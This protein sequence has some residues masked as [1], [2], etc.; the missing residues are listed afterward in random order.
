MGIV[1]V[2][3]LYFFLPS[4]VAN[5]VPLILHRYGLFKF[6]DIRVDFG[7]KINGED[8][9]GATKSY[10]GVVFGVVAGIVV[11]FIQYG[12]FY[13]EWLRFLYIFRYSFIDAFWIGFLLSFGEEFGDVFKSFI[14]RRLS[15]K[16]T[17]PCFLLDRCTFLFSLGFVLLYRWIDFQYVLAILILS[18][19]IPVVANVVAY[20]IGWKDVWW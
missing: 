9:I 7:K 15:L 18:P 6:L 19:L 12:L 17:R 14:K 5:A 3:A 2:K 1:V 4:Y 16:S 10:R 11:A 13:F 20:K 8:L